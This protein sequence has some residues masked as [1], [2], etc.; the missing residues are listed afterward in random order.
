MWVRVLHEQRAEQDGDVRRQRIRD[1][2]RRMIRPAPWRWEHYHEAV[3]AEHAVTCWRSKAILHQTLDTR[4]VIP[5]LPRAAIGKLNPLLNPS[6]EIDGQTCFLAA[7]AI[8][9]VRAS[10]LSSQ[11]CSLLDDEAI[12]IKAIDASRATGARDQ[13]V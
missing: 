8:G 1:K 10:R 4:A 12:V 6:F 2:G 9:T 5:L 3:P 13:H 7:Q 11:V